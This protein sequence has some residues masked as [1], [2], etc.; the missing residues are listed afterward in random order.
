MGHLSN[1]TLP[2]EIL[3]NIFEVEIQS[4]ILNIQCQ[5]ILCNSTRIYPRE[6]FLTNTK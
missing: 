1:F 6:I 5:I 3:H 4:K 2:I